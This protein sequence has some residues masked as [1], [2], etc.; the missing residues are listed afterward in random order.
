MSNHTDLLPVEAVV[1][2]HVS[3]ATALLAAISARLAPPTTAD[4]R[5]LI[6]F[7]DRLCRS[8]GD[9]R[10]ALDTLS[11]LRLPCPADAPEYF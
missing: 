3:K 5:T 6:L 10:Q 9:L 11:E 4:E 8:L 1:S 7:D 2:Q